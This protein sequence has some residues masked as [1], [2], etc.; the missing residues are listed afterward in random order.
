MK[1][2]LEEV[3]KARNYAQAIIETMREPLMV[4]DGNLRV[5]SANN[6]YYQI[7]K[8]APKETENR[9]LYEL[10]NG[11]WDIPALRKL[12]E[13]ILPGNQVF[14]DFEMVQTFPGSAAAPCSSTAGACPW[15][16]HK[17]L[18]LLALEDVTDRQ[19]A[20]AALKESEQKL[21][22]PQ[23][24]THD[25]PGIR[26]SGGLPG[27]ARRTGPEPGGLETQAPAH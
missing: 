24:R 18:I 16:G 26:A 11:Q 5:I 23:R 4:L 2:S 20:E 7:F 19:Q 27:P 10:G 1:G 9:F 3:Q 14:Q 25:L 12:L 15:E 8:A 22:D 21:R 13:E 6:A 17:D